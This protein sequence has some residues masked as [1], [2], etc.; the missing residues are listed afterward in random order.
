MKKNKESLQELCN[1]M[2]RNY[3]HIMGIL[4]YK[5]TENTF[6]TITAENF[7]NLGSKM[8][9]QIHESQR[10]PNKLNLNRA[11]PSHILT[12]ILKVYDKERILKAAE[13]KEDKY[14]KTPIG[15]S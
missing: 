11:T 7:L 2:K 5:V 9:T 3:I 13:K 14:K 6:K 4:E 15:L 8:D 1:T 10:N 12:K